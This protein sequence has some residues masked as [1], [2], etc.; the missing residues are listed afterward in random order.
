LGIS[1]VD[2]LCFSTENWGRPLEEVDFLM[3]LFERVLRPREDGEGDISNP[4]CTEELGYPPAIQAE[5]YL[6]N[7]DTQNNRDIRF[8]AT[9][10]Y[11][12][13]SRRYACNS[14]SSSGATRKLQPDEVMRALLK[15][16]STAGL[17]ISLIV[18]ELEKMQLAHLLDW[19]MQSI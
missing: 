7:G 2:G 15:S 18:P 17:P 6:V 4:V 10:N 12:G 19:L 14:T 3:T 9:A 5:I 8:T 11:G 16:P 1:G 13:C